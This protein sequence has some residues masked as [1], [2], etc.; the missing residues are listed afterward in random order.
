MPAY[1]AAP[2][3]IASLGSETTSQSLVA[4]PLAY[5]DEYFCSRLR[6]IIGM[7]EE[8]PTNTN[9]LI[10]GKSAF[11]IALS[12]ISIACITRLRVTVSNSLLVTFTSSKGGI[13][14]V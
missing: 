3:A 4:R 12:T 6:L 5:C 7:L 11:A 8:P 10:A 9:L 1:F 14:I 2:F 13:G